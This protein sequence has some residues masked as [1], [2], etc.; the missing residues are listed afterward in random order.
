MQRLL[1]WFHNP[2]WSDPGDTRPPPIRRVRKAVPVA[3]VASTMMFAACS[4]SSTPKSTTSAATQSSIPIGYVADLTNLGGE[5]QPFEAAF[6][7]NV[8]AANAHGGVHGVPIKV[9]VCDS[10]VSLNAAAA[11]GQQMVTDHVVAVF[12]DSLESSQ[13]PY[14]QSA[15]IPDFNIGVVAQDGSSPISFMINDLDLGQ[16]AGYFAVGQ[17]AGCTKIGV[18]ST[19]ATTP[20][21]EAQE[22]QVLQKISQ[23]TGIAFA[24]LV[25]AP[26]TAPDMNPYITEIVNKGANC[27]G[28]NAIG[29]QDISALEAIAT[30]VSVKAVQSVTYVD[31]PQEAA[32]LKPIV[33][34]LGSRLIL[35]TATASPQDPPNSLVGSWASD[36][37]DFG[38]KPA[39]LDS[40]SATYWGMLQLFIH[41]GDSLYP[42]VSSATLLSSLN[43]TTF[44]PGI[45]PAVSF[46]NPVADAQ[47]GA[48]VFASWVAPAQFTTG[49]PTTG[50]FRSVL[51]GAV[52]NDTSS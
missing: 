22:Q 46:S 50:P 12:D 43:H 7:G 42:H 31:I 13:L 28:L 25:T 34:S 8:K 48:R 18:L 37:T 5:A 39:F 17:S 16:S 35:Y 47:W 20:A 15:G 21:N 52:D 4:S 19:L 36:Q 23:Q 11:C 44:W 33:R 41:V 49:F 1:D 10:Q 26:S 40:I 2:T 32:S 14:L 38:P 27:I 3:V 6:L 9:I 51:T 29:A 45:S 24:G 30:L